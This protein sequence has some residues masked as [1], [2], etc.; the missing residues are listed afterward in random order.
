MVGVVVSGA[1]FVTGQ[2]VLTARPLFTYAAPGTYT[3]NLTAST[4]GGNQSAACKVT[5]TVP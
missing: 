4:D 3:A 2:T 1:L 5:V